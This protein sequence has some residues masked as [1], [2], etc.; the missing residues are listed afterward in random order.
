AAG[1]QFDAARL[2]VRGELPREGLDDPRSGP[3]GDVEAG[4]GV[5]VPLGAAVAALGPT[6]HR[7]A[8]VAEAAQP[9]PLLPRGELEVGLGPA[10]WPVV[11]GGV[12]TGGAQ[13]VLAGE[14]EAVADAEPALL[15]G[16]DEE[17]TA[18]APPGLAA[19]V[20]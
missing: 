18:E 17:Q 6:H 8:A 13:P 19:Q 4:H 16:V 7:E 5:A 1:A 12:E 11:L 14:V 9:L 2:P 3:P 15:R 10:A 20:L